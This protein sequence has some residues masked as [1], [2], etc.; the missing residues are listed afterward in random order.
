MAVGLPST[1][2]HNYRMIIMASPCGKHTVFQALNGLSNL[3]LAA[4][5]GTRMKEASD[6]PGHRI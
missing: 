2:R 6:L 3:I 5:A 1:E 4:R